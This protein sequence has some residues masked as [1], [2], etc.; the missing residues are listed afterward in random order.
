MGNTQETVVV[1]VNIKPSGKGTILSIFGYLDNAH[2]KHMFLG[3]NLA[4]LVL[5]SSGGPSHINLRR[6][7]DRK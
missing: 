3:R 4:D 2:P 5:S 1:G 6:G 7:S